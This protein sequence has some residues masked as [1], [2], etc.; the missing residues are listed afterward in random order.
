MFYLVD[1]PT[2]ISS[3]SAVARVRR[4]TKSAKAGH[5]GTLDPLASGLLI[6][7][8]NGSTKLIPYFENDR[9]TYRFTVDFS[10]SSESLDLGTETWDVDAPDLENARKSMGNGGLEAL[11]SKFRGKIL[12]APPK[13]SALRINGRRAYH[14][15][16]KGKD[17]EIPERETEVFSL[18]IESFVFPFA[19]FT[20]EVSAG[21]YVRSLARDIGSE[22]DTGAVVTE[23]RRTAIG[24]LSVERAHPPLE[25]GTEN[26]IDPAE[27]LPDM[28]VLRPSDEIVKNLVAG[29]SQPSPVRIDAGKNVLVRNEEDYVSLCVSQNSMLI[30]LRNAIG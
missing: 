13:Y 2:G 1:K 25:A 14:L 30:P 21:T 11:L 29:I 24:R 19:T 15:A 10:R 18:E 20:A 8:T 4:I 28:V 7:A 26:A 9:K 6:V 23:L 5:T 17:F 16:R 27:I 3:F 12:Q 22:F